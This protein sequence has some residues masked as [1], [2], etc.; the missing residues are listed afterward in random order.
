LLVFAGLTVIIQFSTF[1]YC[2]KVYLASLADGASTTNSSG[3][4]SYQASVITMTPRQ[5][6]RRVKRVVELQWRGIAIVLLIIT[7]VI[8]F[9][10]VFV[11]LDNNQT[12][13]SE[14]K[15][16]TVK[17][18][19]CQLANA[20]KPVKEAKE[21]CLTEAKDLVTG[22]ATVTAVLVL[23]SVGTQEYNQR[24]ITNYIFRRTA[25]GSCS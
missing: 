7:D 23:L 19:A 1:G 12:S 9:S 3:L 5:A 15:S 16:K 6:Y 8:F 4:P 14:D 2:I 10:V 22:L 13:V 18:I 11:M 21:I 20:H 24:H 25:S 17:W